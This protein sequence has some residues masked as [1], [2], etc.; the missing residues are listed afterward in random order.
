[1]GSTLLYLA[2]QE[3]YDKNCS[4]NYSV[5]TCQRPCNPKQVLAE[6]RSDCLG[7][8]NGLCV[9][10]ANVDCGIACQGQVRTFRSSSSTNAV[11]PRLKDSCLLIHLSAC[12]RVPLPFR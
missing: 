3:K 1:M 7:Q 5:L 4:C 10:H 2:T 12:S 6:G 8:D 11:A 9:G